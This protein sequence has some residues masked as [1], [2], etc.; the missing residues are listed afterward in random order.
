MIV[1]AIVAILV[2][3]GVPALRDLVLSNRQVSAVN[4]LV[5]AFQLARSDA[6]T[7]R[8]GQLANPA[9]ISVCASGNAAAT[10]CGSDW[11]NGWIVFRNLDADDE[12]DGGDVVLRVSP[13]ARGLNIVSLAD[14]VHYRSDGRAIAAAS[15]DFCDKRGN[16]AARRVV[17]EPTGRVSSGKANG[18]DCP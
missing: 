12:L 15:F 17:I 7:F 16:G 6:V 8:G 3:V 2:G 5:T 4:E 10:E 14:T 1:L 11:S 9:R 18:A 13:Q